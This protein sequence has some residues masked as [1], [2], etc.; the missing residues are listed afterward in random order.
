MDH[1]VCLVLGIFPLAVETVKRW[2]K[3]KFEMTDHVAVKSFLGVEFVYTNER[4]CLRLKHFINPVL[5]KFGI[6]YSKQVNT[7]LVHPGRNVE[8][9]FLVF[10]RFD[11]NLY[12][13][14]IGALLYISKGTRS[15]NRSAVG[16]MSRRASIRLSRTVQRSRGSFDT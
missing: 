13:Q 16:I 4:I 8:S 14:A 2:L 1:C 15:E 9:N 12:K 5:H 11:I 7:P 3:S 6:F 10:R